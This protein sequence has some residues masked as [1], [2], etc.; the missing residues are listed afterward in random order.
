[1]VRCSSKKTV[2]RVMVAG[3]SGDRES[4]EKNLCFIRVE[5]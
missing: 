3:I 2:S 4:A 1:M 5:S